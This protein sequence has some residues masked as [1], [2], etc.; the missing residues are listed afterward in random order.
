MLM[1]LSFTGLVSSSSDFTQGFL[2]VL[3]N[4]MAPGRLSFTQ[5]RSANCEGARLSTRSLNTR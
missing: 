1:P 4:T 3:S 2:S 5:G